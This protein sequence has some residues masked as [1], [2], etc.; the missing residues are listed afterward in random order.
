MGSEMSA[1]IPTNFLHTFRIINVENENA[2]EFIRAH[3]D[4]IPAKIHKNSILSRDDNRRNV[5]MRKL[6]ISLIEQI[7]F[8][9][10]SPIFVAIWER[11]KNVTHNLRKRWGWE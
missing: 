7:Q 9:S 3:R 8:L 1:E 6:Y 10:H 4:K 5:W 2:R 11:K